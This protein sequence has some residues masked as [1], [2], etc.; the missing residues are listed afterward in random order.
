[1]ATLRKIFCFLSGV[2]CFVLL[3]PNLTSWIQISPTTYWG[4]VYTIL[5]FVWFIVTVPNKFFM[6]I[7]KRKSYLNIV[8]VLLFLMGPVSLGLHPQ[9]GVVY[10][11]N[12]VPIML[13]AGCSATVDFIDIFLDWLQK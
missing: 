7:N 6:A 13:S 9:S 12:F 11:A 2:I 5:T 8:S 10:S 1:M 3:I 4:W